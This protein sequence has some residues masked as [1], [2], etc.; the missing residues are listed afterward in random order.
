MNYEK[1]MSDL[2]RDNRVTFGSA[3]ETQ[4]IL[5]NLGVDQDMKQLG[6]G[7]YRADMSVRSTKQMELYADRYSKAVSM[8]LEPPAESIGLLIPRTV[9]G[10]FQ[11]SG[12]NVSNDHLV[13]VHT[14]QGTDIVAPD[15]TGSEATT[16]SKSRFDELARVLCPSMKLQDKMRVIKGDT[17]HLHALRKCILELITQQ[18][19]PNE[20]QLSG[21][22]ASFIFWMDNSINDYSNEKHLI[23]IRKKKR[24]AKSA[25]EY[26]H[27]NFRQNVHTE[28]LCRTSS[29]GIRTLQR[30]FREYFDLTI[31]EYLKM[32]RLEAAQRELAAGDS[33]HYTVTDIA[34]KNG[35]KHLGR[36]SV[37]F[38][39]RFGVVPSDVL[40]AKH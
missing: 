35:C 20:E 27:A 15:L 40:G 10:I 12:S 19:E 7:V 32:V 29:V 1:F 37:E 34:L 5:S 36:F 28:D 31:T 24:I 22:I 18:P 33:S 14:D 30:S 13:F 9:N 4:E 8:Y 25:Q 3:E 26:I 17:A 23:S 6:K 2:P 16:I 11:A 21:L 38:H 39:E